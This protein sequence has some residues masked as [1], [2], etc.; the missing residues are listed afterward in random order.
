MGGM[1]CGA[2]TLC[3]A[4]VVLVIGRAASERVTRHACAFHTVWCVWSTSSI[5]GMHGAPPADRPE[6]HVAQAALGGQVSNRL[7]PIAWV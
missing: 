4:H 2:H 7:T 5:S 6:R 3:F 1:C